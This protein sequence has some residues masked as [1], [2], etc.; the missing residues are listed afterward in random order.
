MPPRV[1]LALPVYNGE[2]FVAAAIQSVLDQTFEDFELII[3]DNASADRTP[4]ICRA[5]SER[6]PRVRY[7]RNEQ[8]LGAGGNFNRGFNATS[9]VYFKWCAHDDFISPDFLEK[10]VHSL[11]ADP[12][13]VIAYGTLQGVNE[14]GR[15]TSYVEELMPDMTGMT[16]AQRF[17]TLIAMHGRDGV[18]FGLVRR[19]A[20]AETSLHASYYGSDCALLAELA[21]LGTFVRVPS[22][23]LYNRDHPQRS[24]NI[25]SSERLAWQD[26]AAAGRNAFELSNRLAH[27]VAI[28]FR[29]RRRAPLHRTLF[30]IAVWAMHPVLLGR[31]ALEGIGAVSPSLREK[32][33]AAGKMVLNRLAG[34][35][36][37]QVRRTAREEV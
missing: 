16:P 28:A 29:H 27:L 5:F 1:S 22:I 15:M 11:E 36:D 35:A 24:V 26:A 23:V 3:T 14:D 13:A 30:G 19:S 12:D 20:L 2:N 9:G 6:D 8:N 21:L 17:R 32:L 25:H 34:R 33:R 18:I 7:L 31:F 4:Q 10:A 37:R